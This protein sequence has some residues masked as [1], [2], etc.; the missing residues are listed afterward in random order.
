MG[1]ENFKIDAS[2]AEELTKTRVQ[3]LLA[4]TVLVFV[5]KAETRNTN[6]MEQQGEIKSIHASQKV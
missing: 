3:F 5:F 1:T 6:L 2:W 4:P